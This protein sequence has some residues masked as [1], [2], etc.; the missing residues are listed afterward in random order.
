[1]KPLTSHATF[2]AVGLFPL[3]GTEFSPEGVVYGCSVSTHLSW[4]LLPGGMRASL[5]GELPTLCWRSHH[6]GD[7]FGDVAR[8]SDKGMMLASE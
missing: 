3:L 7:R 1:M 6:A 2:T 4:R 5:C 8:A